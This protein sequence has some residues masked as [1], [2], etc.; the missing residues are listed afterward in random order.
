MHTLLSL[1]AIICG[2]VIVCSGAPLWS[3]PC[4]C[5]AALGLIARR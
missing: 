2:T 1:S 5:L 3:A 4:W